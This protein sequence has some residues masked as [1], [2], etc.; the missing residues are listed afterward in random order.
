MRQIIADGFTE[1]QYFDQLISRDALANRDITETVS[2]ILDQVRERGDEALR[3]FGNTFDGGSP[4][5][6]ELP[7]DSMKQGYDMADLDFKTALL[8]A[9]ENIIEFHKK[10]RIEDYEIQREN[11]VRLGM[12]TRGLDRVGIYVPGGTASYPSTV[13]MNAIPAKLAGVKEIVMVTPPMIEY[14]DGKGICV[15][16]PDILIA[17]YIAGVDRVFLAGGAQAIAALTYGTES[18]P[19]VDKIVGPGNIYVATAKRLLFG[20]VD[21]DMIAG[22]SEIL[23]LADKTANPMFIASDMLSQAEHDKMAAAILI[24]DDEVVGKAAWL[25]LEKQRNG[26]ERQDILDVALEE[27]S[28]IIFCQTKDEMIA[29]ANFIA[30]EHLEIM[31][32]NPMEVLKDIHNAGSVFC[33]DYSPEPL[34]DYFAGTNHVLPTSGTARFASPLGVYS[35]VKQMSYTYYEK[36]ALQASKDHIQVIAQREGLPAHGNSISVRFL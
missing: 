1:Y 16:N 9:K 12:I 36:E 35:F 17:A 31:M 33:G 29:L 3:D 25:E 2:A 13:L 18:F 26:Q 15:A 11:G 30:P 6:F 10:Q 23:I 28:A 19:R 20:T 27:Q 8:L 24:T 32:E 22:P 34:G 21:I 14:R 7:K 4:D 5:V